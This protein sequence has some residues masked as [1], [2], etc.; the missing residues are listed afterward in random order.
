MGRS[1]QMTCGS[2]VSTFY[3]WLY[4]LANKL[5]YLPTYLPVCLLGNWTEHRFTHRDESVRKGEWL[6][7]WI[8]S[9]LETRNRRRPVPDT[10][11]PCSDRLTRFAAKTSPNHFP[12]QPSVCRLR[13]D[14]REFCSSLLK[15][16]KSESGQHSWMHPNYFVT[17]P[18]KTNAIWRKEISKIGKNDVARTF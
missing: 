5:T 13:R 11:L 8:S 15:S 3:C 12:L 17:C 6:A 16:L 7:A 10:A 14:G 1:A 18:A 2:S 9:S 4:S